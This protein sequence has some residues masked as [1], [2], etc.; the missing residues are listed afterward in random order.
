[1]TNWFSVGIQLEIEFSVLKRISEDWK[2]DTERF[3][4]EVINFWLCDD[5]DPSWSK[6]AQAV[7]DIGGYS[8]I[9]LTLKKN[10]G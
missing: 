2:S 3:K 7:E 5:K 10:Q 4:I 1:M 9:V 6:L 8:N